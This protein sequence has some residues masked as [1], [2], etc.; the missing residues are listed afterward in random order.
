MRGFAAGLLVLVVVVVAL[1]QLDLLPGGARRAPPPAPVPDV[2]AAVKAGDA[3]ALK[4][5]LA[6]GAD[7]HAV[8]DAG[9]T[10][11]MAAATEGASDPVL[12]ALL[13]AGAD[14]NARAAN[15]V[16]ALMLAARDGTTDAVLYLLNAGADP[17][18]R[19][20]QDK[21]VLDYVA[22]NS[23]VRN[24]GLYPRLVELTKHPF[25]EG[26]PSGYVVPIPGATVSSRQHHL[27]GSPR[28]YRHGIH[29][30]FDWFNGTVSVAIDYGT[31]VEAIVQGTVLRADLDYQE[32]NLEQYKAVIDE[33]VR[34]LDPSPDLL[35]KLRGRQVWVRAPGG[36]IVRYAHL[37]AIA[38]GIVVGA[39]VKQG[40]TVAYAGNSGTEEAARD[41]KT[42]PHLHL[43]IWSGDTYLGQNM[44]VDQIYDVA[45]QVF[46]QASRPPYH[47]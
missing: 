5:A 9:L 28:E 17:T 3:A 14:V 27:P 12:G 6:S 26:W 20:A 42:D 21:G 10:P 2:F 39:R 35:D 8:N 32:M 16:D 33:S 7:L 23:D 40:E 47:D 37:S 41:T 31:P 19:D 34:S 29:Q 1:W 46:G 18:L 13:D 4:D 11:L 38:D 22:S 44:S 15:G 36:F 24:S 25:L 45:A 30:G 43:E